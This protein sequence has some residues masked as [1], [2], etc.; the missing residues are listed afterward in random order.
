MREFCIQ[1]VATDIIILKLIIGRIHKMLERF[2]ID[3][4][5]EQDYVMRMIKDSIRFLAKIF[6]N[7]DAVTYQLP[8][9]EE[10]TQIDYLHK[11][12]LSLIYQGKINEAEN[13]LFS[14]LDS[15]NKKYMELALD[16]YGRLNS[17]DREFLDNNNFCREEIEQGLKEIAKEFGMP[18]YRQ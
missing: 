6:L 3:Y 4:M 7:K 15:T 16:F 9:E 1:G 18:N 17:F 5:F 11:Q 12:L 14:E 13:L 2:V 10:Y 8:D